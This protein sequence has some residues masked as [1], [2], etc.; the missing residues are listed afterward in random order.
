MTTTK[1]II[2]AALL[3]ASISSAHA[4]NSCMF[5]GK[6]AIFAALAATSG[7]S[8]DTYLKDQAEVIENA[9]INKPSQAELDNALKMFGK[10]YDQAT[11]H[12]T[13]LKPRQTQR[14][15]GL[16]S[17]IMLGKCIDSRD[18][19]I[20]PAEQCLINLLQQLGVTRSFDDQFISDIGQCGND[21]FP[22]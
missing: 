13:D 22:K 6:N 16:F 19:K 21:D 17:E 8:R 4:A 12:L 14:G 20:Q 5:F 18:S 10:I 1:K 9:V 15:I 3:A 7:V 2:A 11:V